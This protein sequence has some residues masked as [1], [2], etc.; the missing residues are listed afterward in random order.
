MKLKCE[1]N[2]ASR[3][4][5]ARLGLLV[6][7]LLALNL[8]NLI[9]GL[10][11]AGA[12]AEPAISTGLLSQNPQ[13]LVENSTALQAGRYT[14]WLN[15]QPTEDGIRLSNEGLQ[16]PKWAGQWAVFG[17]VSSL[18]QSFAVP[19]NGLRATWQAEVPSDTGLEVDLRVS[20]DGQ[21]WTLW[22]ILDQS[23][24]RTNFGAEN[25]FLYA[26]YRVRL[27]S[28]GEGQ[29]PTFKNIRLEAN[30]RDLNNVQTAH[31]FGLANAA[32][33]APA[34]VSPPT[35]SVYATREGLVGERTANGHIIQPRDHFV[36]LPSWTALSEAGKGDY[37]VKITTPQGR[38]AIAPVWDTGPWNFKD[39]YWHNPRNEFK[40]LP[41]GVP[42]A[43][44]AFLEKHNAGRNESGRGIYNP[45][46]IDIADGTYWDDLG[47][48]GASAGKLDVTFLWE[49]S[50][51]SAPDIE[52]VQ[53]YGAWQNGTQI[54]WTTGTPA[55]S[56]VEYGLTPAYG[57]TTATYD[58][59]GTSHNRVLTDLIPGRTYNFRVHNRDIY[60]TEA[61]SPNLTF[62][63][64]PATLVGLTTFQNDRGIGLTTSKDNSRLL[65][66]GARVNPTFWSDNPHADYLAGGQTGPGVLSQTGNLDLDFVPVCDDKGGNCTMGYGSGYKNFVRF[67]NGKG[68]TLEVGL[69][70]DSSISPASVSLMVEGNYADGTKL[71]RYNPPDSTDQKVS[72]HF[73]F[74]WDSRGVSVWFD[75]T[76]LGEP[77][78]F[79]ATNLTIWFIGAGRAKDDIVAANY[80]N[81]G[82]SADALRAGS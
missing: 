18:P 36:S 32:Q 33:N 34:P 30:R 4:W 66:L 73:H 10:G 16:T 41:V 22:Q 52:G 74:V 17:L 2:G 15:T 28:N 8:L 80:Q 60:G 13:I 31:Y 64:T 70:H 47:L 81:I 68:E 63:T 55:N 7:S 72:H 78:P 42:Q 79:D 67:A 65:L 25:A 50:L 35:Y 5:T 75:N 49:G 43:E 24:Q 3:L 48:E 23:G 76:R 59:L 61:V 58:P 26:Q 21:N 9:D 19:F 27:F 38:T 44:K 69:I 53:A 82:F 51:P 77:I 57:Q 54:K 71:R 39:D 20:P 1:S 14:N 46:G 37:R 56:W 40:D 6:V 62:S 11:L 45:S 29:S 12:A